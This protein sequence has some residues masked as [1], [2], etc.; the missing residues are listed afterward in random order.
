MTVV[1]AEPALPDNTPACL[2][3]HGPDI[4]IMIGKTI[5]SR[6]ADIAA[7]L[8]AALEKEVP[9]GPRYSGGC[10]AADGLSSVS[11]WGDG[12]QSTDVAVA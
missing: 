10:N 4:T 12:E 11:T 5:G 7:Q 6:L 8:T 2:V 1:S 3:Q 9:A